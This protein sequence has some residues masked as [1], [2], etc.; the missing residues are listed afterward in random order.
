MNQ[1]STIDKITDVI[2]AIHNASI[3]QSLL[4]E[5][6]LQIEGMEF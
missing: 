2:T 1:Q 4:S 6:I 3:N 5:D